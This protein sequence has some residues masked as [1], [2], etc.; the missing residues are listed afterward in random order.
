MEN[1]D[2]KKIELTDKIINFIKKKKFI[3][4]NGLLFSLIIL[5]GIT[6]FQYNKEV[7]NKKI[8]VKYIKAGLYLSSKNL[9]KSK[10]LY[11]EII[12]DKNKF[13]SI[14]SLNK[15][16]ENTLEQNSDEIL[17]LFKIIENLS[18]DKEQKNL[19]KFKKALYLLKI[20]QKDEGNK[21]LKEIIEDDSIWKEAVQ[22]LT[23]L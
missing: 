13:Y 22:N 15:I 9:D 3:I 17:N 4:F 2:L 19:V 20:S 7:Q 16:I 23:T 5:I 8:S 11:K 21:L 1:K 10:K 12:N 6:Y 14:L 18:L